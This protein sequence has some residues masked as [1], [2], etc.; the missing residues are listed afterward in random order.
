ML[1]DVRLGAGQRLF[2]RGDTIT[3]V[4]FLTRGRIA[5]HHEDERPPDEAGP[6]AVLGAGA[7]LQP[8]EAPYT[9]I[10]VTDSQLFALDAEALRHIEGEHPR[11][12]Y[13]LQQ[14]ISERSADLNDGEQGVLRDLFVDHVE[15][16]SLAADTV[17]IRQGQALDCM[18][19]IVAGRFD[20]VLDGS[21]SRIRAIG[22]GDVVGE[23]SYYVR[24]AATA[25]VIAR[26]DA[27]VRQ[28]D[29]DT[30]KRLEVEQPAVAAAFHQRFARVLARRLDRDTRLKARTRGQ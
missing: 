26:T 9:A 12:A 11:V 3:R 27:V 29:H 17:L 13:L 18:F 2:T 8:I 24:S 7:Q 16:R 25:T 15:E 30:L 22:P 23:L 5:L 20:V 28:L 19:L 14:L 4:H 10:A 21:S 6:A 1:V